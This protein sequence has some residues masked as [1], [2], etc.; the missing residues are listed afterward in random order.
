MRFSHTGHSQC[1]I[2]LSPGPPAHAQDLHILLFILLQLSHLLLQLLRALTL[3]VLIPRTLFQPLPLPLLLLLPLPPQQVAHVLHESLEV[4]LGFRG[5]VRVDGFGERFGCERLRF[6]RE[7]LSLSLS[8][9]H[10]HT[11]THTHT[12]FSSPAL[13]DSRS[14]QRKV[15][16]CV[17]VCVCVCLPPRSGRN[18]YFLSL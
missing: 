14:V 6:R 1:R 16:W 17:C 5:L 15:L 3:S 8:L 12:F 2:N 11:H 10:T 4:G 18:F 9:T 7:R 13:E